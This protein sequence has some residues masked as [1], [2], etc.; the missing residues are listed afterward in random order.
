MLPR[1]LVALLCAVGTVA[2]SSPTWA[3]PSGTLTL[4]GS[5]TSSVDITLTAETSFDLSRMT[6]V[7]RGRF[8]GFYAEAID[9]PHNDRVG[10]DHDR[11]GGVNLRDFH[12][13]GEPP[14]TVPLVQS[15]TLRPGRF[16]LYLL[17]DGPS[18]LRVP[19]QGLTSKTF[20]PTRLERA[21]SA[22][23]T[24]ILVNQVQADNTQPI[25][26]TGKRAISAAYILV[27][28]WRVYAG[29]IGA[30]LR[31]PE[32]QCGAY[33][34]G[35]D[36]AYWSQG[37]SPLQP[38]AQVFGFTYQPGTLPPGRYDAWEGAL[39]AGTLDFASGAAFS[40]T[41]S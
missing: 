6:T 9:R 11:V 7:G 21:T 33:T 38:T 22:V 29:D 34:N 4:Q 31:K 20:R 12:G 28:N 15:S 30:C 19:V 23:K 13:P 37:V 18:T 26:L 10:T 5:R 39:N 27:G 2:V 40:L 32:G 41:L 17:A 36:G 16:R 14:P 1:R 24:D 8:I 25:I 35:A 3:S